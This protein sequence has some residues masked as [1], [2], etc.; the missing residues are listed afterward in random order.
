M[1]AQLP[2]GAPGQMQSQAWPNSPPSSAPI[3]I[4]GVNSPPECAAAKAAAHSE[5]L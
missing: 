1:T 3:V 5:Q 2:M 4:V